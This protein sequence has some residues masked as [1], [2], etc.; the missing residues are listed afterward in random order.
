MA[1][2]WIIEAQKGRPEFSD[3]QMADFHDF[4]LAHP[5]LKY[6]LTPA[7][8]PVSND[9]RAWYFGAIIKTIKATVP[10]W[11]TLSDEEVHEILKKMFNFFEFHNP[12]TNRTERCGKSAVGS[13]SNTERAMDYI[14]KIRVWLAEEYKTELPDPEEYKRKLNSAELK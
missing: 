6:R 5:K 14:E 8:N 2:F 7:K 13:E 12:L 11:N 9:V 4:S 1:K 3:F 10:Q